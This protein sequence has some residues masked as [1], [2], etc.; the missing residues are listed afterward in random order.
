[1]KNSMRKVQ[2]ARKGAIKRL[3]QT[4]RVVKPE[5]LNAEQRRREINDEVGSDRQSR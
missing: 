5:L 1:M 3:A 4:D 2:K